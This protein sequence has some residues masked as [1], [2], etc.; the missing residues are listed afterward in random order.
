MRLVSYLTSGLLALTGV[1]FVAAPAHAAVTGTYDGTT[2]T[3][4]SDA[5]SDTMVLTCGAN[6]VL[7]NGVLPT[8]S[9]GTCTSRL[10]VMGNGGDD[11]IDIRGLSG[12]TSRPSPSMRVT[13]TSGSTAPAGR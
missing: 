12:N 9:G 8:G 11:V 1:A 7:V 3:I 2:T 5:S 13:A 10:V 6:Q 4:A